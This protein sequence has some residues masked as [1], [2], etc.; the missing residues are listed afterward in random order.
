MGQRREALI[1]RRRHLDF[2][3]ETLA[4]RLNVG[5]ST[6]TKWEY[7][8]RLPAQGLRRKLAAALE[9]NLIELDRLLGIEPVIELDGHEVPS[10]LNTYESLAQAAGS[11]SIV[12]R[13]A[14]HGLLQTKA[15][16]ATVERYGPLQ[17]TDQQVIERVDL[18]LAR[19]AVLYREP[20]PLQLTIL[21]AETVLL[22]QVGGAEVMREQLD[23]L[24]EMAERPNVDLRLLPAD[25]R[26]ACARGGFELLTSATDSNPFMAVTF[27]PAGG[28]YYHENAHEIRP[29][30]AMFDH[31]N[32]AA[33]SDLN[34]T[35]R[36]KTI[37]ETY[38]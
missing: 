8:M 7:G 2:T 27:G 29:F 37:R 9:L 5:L 12:E 15:Y 17:L 6:V 24:I 33:E 35:R 36:L 25:G 28:V 38:R 31:L 34:T 32:A 22:D 14:V 4:R 16:A 13:S 11:L 3:Q 1:A 20:E 21:I 23:H 19:Q 18:R 10:W 30:I 26:A